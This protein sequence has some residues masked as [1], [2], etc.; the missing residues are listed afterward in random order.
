MSG[1]WPGGFI[2]KTAPTVVGPT[3]GEGGSA[4]GIWTLDQVADYESKGLW[5]TRTLDRIMLTWG[6]NNNGQIGDETIT[7]R[8]SP[9]QIG[10]VTTWAFSSG[11]GYTSYGI[12]Q[13]GTLWAWG[14]GGNGQLGDGN[15]SSTNTPTQEFTGATDWEKIAAICGWTGLPGP[16]ESEWVSRL[17]GSWNMISSRMAMTGLALILMFLFFGFLHVVF[18]FTGKRD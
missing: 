6:Y 5:P 16:R 18:R 10:A 13:D 9:I 14:Q 8:S 2:N 15:L 1:K 11:G 12:K 4:S 17:R 7:N 3:D